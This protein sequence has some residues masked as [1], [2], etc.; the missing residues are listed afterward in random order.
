MKPNCAVWAIDPHEENIRPSKSSLIDARNL[1][2][3]SLKNVHPVYIH[4]DDNIHECRPWDELKEYLGHLEAGDT[5]EAEVIFA[6]GVTREALVHKIINFARERKGE[7]ILLSTHGRS[8][9]GEFVFGS[10]AHDL[11]EKSPLPVLILSPDKTTPASKNVM[12]A[13][14]FSEDSFGAYKDFLKFVGGKADTVL[15][16]HAVNIPTAGMVSLGLPGTFPEMLLEEE[17]QWS[18]ATMAKWEIAAQS[19]GLS[20]HLKSKVVEEFVRPSE[21]ILKAARDENIGTI[22]IFAHGAAKGSYFLGSTAR[23]ILFANDFNL[24]ACGPGYVQ[25]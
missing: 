25:I 19:A 10:F 8:V 18:E 4:S 5:A 1:L 14:D 13:T 17:V 6:P 23:D 12:F 11:L 21:S 15:L 16:F 3:G 20:L 24:W 9:L 2:G 22:G 7:L